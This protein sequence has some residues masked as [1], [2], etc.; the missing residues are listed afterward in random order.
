M[1][2][3]EGVTLDNYNANYQFIGP[4]WVL[5]SEPTHGNFGFLNG[6]ITTFTI[7]CGHFWVPTVIT[8]EIFVPILELPKMQIE[9][10]TI[11][12]IIHRPF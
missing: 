7:I 10:I 8:S 1:L 11:L 9:R 2:T 6:P 4:F 3:S 5:L 12:P